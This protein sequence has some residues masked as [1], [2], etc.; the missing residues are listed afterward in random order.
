MRLR[1]DLCKE[2][3]FLFLAH[4]TGEHSVDRKALLAPRLCVSAVIAI[5]EFRIL[6]REKTGG[7]S[8]SAS[9]ELIRYFR[10]MAGADDN[11]PFRRLTRR[12]PGGADT[13]AEIR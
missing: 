13:F 12:R 10:E 7:T 4:P 8:P 5:E 2:D 9:H 11:R 3:W 6:N 1:S